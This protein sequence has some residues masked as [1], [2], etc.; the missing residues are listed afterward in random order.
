[1]ILLRRVVALALKAVESFLAA[2]R[3]NQFI[4]FNEEPASVPTF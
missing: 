2:G 1:M 4:V 3:G